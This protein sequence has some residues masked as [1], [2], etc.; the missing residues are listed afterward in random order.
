MKVD[1]TTYNPLGEGG[2]STFEIP[3]TLD[4]DMAVSAQTVA[5]SQPHEIEYTLHFD[6]ATLEP[7][8]Q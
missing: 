5:M 2:N 6:S 7:A 1:G 3:V 8:A 4:E